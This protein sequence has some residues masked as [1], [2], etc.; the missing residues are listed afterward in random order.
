MAIWLT[1][2][3]LALFMIGLGLRL[4]VGR[5]EANRDDPEAPL[6]CRRIPGP[7]DKA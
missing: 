2:P 3:F 7:H 4:A 1:L 5:V 6:A